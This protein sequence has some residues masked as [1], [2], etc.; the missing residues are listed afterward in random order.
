MVK[1]QSAKTA[2]PLCQAF[3]FFLSCHMAEAQCPAELSDKGGQAFLLYPQGQAFTLYH[4]S[5]ESGQ[6]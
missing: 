4:S 5:D 1:H 2:I 3:I 6:V